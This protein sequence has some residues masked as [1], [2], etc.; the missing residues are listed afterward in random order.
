MKKIIHFH[1]EDLTSWVWWI[2]YWDQLVFVIPSGLVLG[3]RGLQHGC[4]QTVK[5]GARLQI[6]VDPGLVPLRGAVLHLLVYHDATSSYLEL[7]CVIS[8]W[9]Q[10]EHNCAPL[11]NLNGLQYAADFGLVRW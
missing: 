5:N 3:T 4:V 8:S 11:K 9:I 1:V 2:L 6:M 10:Q 7:H